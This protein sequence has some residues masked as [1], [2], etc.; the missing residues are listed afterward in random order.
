MRLCHLKFGEADGFFSTL[1]HIIKPLHL[2]EDSEE[3]VFECGLNG[4]KSLLDEFS[5]S[6]FYLDLAQG[7]LT[8][9]FLL[10]K[11]HFLEQEGHLHVRLL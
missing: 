6:G 11:L 4:V 10:Q 5:E 9:L 1:N 8:L 3:L 2:H 7:K